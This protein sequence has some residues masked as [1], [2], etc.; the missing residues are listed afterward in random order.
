MSPTKIVLD[1]SVIAKWFFP[2]E[3]ESGVALQIRDRFTTKGL[4]IFEPALVYYEIN[5][6]L[7]SAAGNLRI[8]QRLAKDAYQGFLDL[9]FVIYFSGELMELTLE[10][11]LSL[12]IS[13]YDASY[14]SLAE[15]L[16]IPLYTADI[17]LIEKARSPWI[18]NLK[19]FLED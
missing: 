7:R 5:N 11:A 9:D 16:Q 1:S 13:S 15:Y 10:K 18:R 6:L 4:M 14:L 2:S 3:E 19:T 12:N 17:K 8:D